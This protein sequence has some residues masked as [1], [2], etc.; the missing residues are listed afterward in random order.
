MDADWA[1]EVDRGVP[2]NEGDGVGCCCGE[3]QAN[4]RVAVQSRRKARAVVF[5]K[6]S[7]G[8]VWSKMTPHRDIPS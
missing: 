3:L 4:N 5:I 8:M 2:V 7:T 1:G 6:K